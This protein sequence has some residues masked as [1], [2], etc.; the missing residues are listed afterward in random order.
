MSSGIDSARKT[1]TPVISSIHWAQGHSHRTSLKGKRKVWPSGHAIS[2]TPASFRA[3]SDCGGS[4]SVTRVLSSLVFKRVCDLIP[5]F[6]ESLGR[7]FGAVIRI[8]TLNAHR[9]FSVSECPTHH[10][11][12]FEKFVHIRAVF[13]TRYMRAAG[14]MTILAL[15]SQ[16]MWRSLFADI[17]TFISE[18]FLRMPPGDMA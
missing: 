3:L 16:Q 12:T 5:E 6:V 10:L 9:L 4:E 18:H 17:A 13:L 8:V 15:L 1:R 14:P 11:A 7:E 2:K